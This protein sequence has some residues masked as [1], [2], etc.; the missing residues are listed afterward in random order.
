[1][2]YNMIIAS[3]TKENNRTC[4]HFL[5]WEYPYSTFEFK[6]WRDVCYSEINQKHSEA[7][8]EICRIDCGTAIFSY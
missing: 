8:D 1:M 7:G 3:W 4:G 2:R 6:F 5:R